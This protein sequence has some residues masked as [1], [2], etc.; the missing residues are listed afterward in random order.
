[1]LLQLSH[2]RTNDQSR[3]TDLQGNPTQGWGFS[4]PI[5]Y[6]ISGFNQTFMDGPRFFF[7]SAADALAAHVLTG[8][9]EIPD[10][11]FDDSECEATMYDN[12]KPD[13]PANLIEANGLFYGDVS[14]RED[15]A[16]DE[17]LDEDDHRLQH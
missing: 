16:I 6:G 5:L 3:P 11:D 17:L 7:R 1:M 14:V 13:Q 10:L 12:H 15:H 2:G 4:G 9:G 8:W